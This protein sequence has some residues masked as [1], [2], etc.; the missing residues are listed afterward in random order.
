MSSGDGSDPITDDEVVFRR[1]SEQSG[2]YDSSLSR[3]VRWQAFKPN[4]SDRSGISVWRAKY[5]TARD[6]A[7]TNARPD[8]RYYI[9]VLAASRLRAAGVEVRPTPEE[10]GPGHAS[11][12]NINFDDYECDKDRIREL[13]NTIAETLI[14]RVEGPFGPFDTSIS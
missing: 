3:P 11:L 9:L 13:L 4:E 7:A 14:E 5:I 1:V 8:R 12:V 10:G 2:H 6:T